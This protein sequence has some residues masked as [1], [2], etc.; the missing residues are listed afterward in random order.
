MAG[1]QYIVK[2]FTIGSAATESSVFN[3]IDEHDETLA[4]CAIEIIGT[5]T[6]NTANI[7][8]SEKS[9]SGFTDRYDQF[10]SKLTF[11]VATDRTVVLRPA[12]YAVFKP[13]MKIALSAGA[14]GAVTGR[15]YFRRV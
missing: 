15:A 3:V 11:S 14:S 4:L 9:T 12:D 10:G 5:L 2:T 13:Y 1:I 6:A 8:T 7:Q